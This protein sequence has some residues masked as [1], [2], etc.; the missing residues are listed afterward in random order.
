MFVSAVDSRSLVRDVLLRDGSTLRLEA[1]APEDFGDIKEFYEELSPE[2]R[3]LRFHGHGRVDMVARAEAEASGVD[4][5]ALIGRHDGRVIAVASYNG[6]REKC[7]A[8]VAFAVADDLQGRGIGTR[9][10][11]QLAEIAA[12]RGIHR[13]DADVMVADQRMLRVFEHAGFVVRRRGSLGEVTLS[14]DITP[15]D[16]VRERIGE[17]DHVGAVAALRPILAPRSI[18]VVGA[19][20]TPGNVGRAILANV[21]AGGFEGV[22]SPVNR[23]GGVVCSLNAAH[24]LRDLAVAPELVIIAPNG[25]DVPEFAAEAAETGAKALLVLPAGP[26]DDGGVSAAQELRLLEILRGA[27]LRMV[28]PGSL[29][30]LN[31]AP[32]V[33]LNATFRGVTVQPGGLAIGS[34]A[35]GLG[36][37]LLGHAAARGLGVS[38]FVSLGGR[39]DVSTS[40]LLEW[41]GDDERTT[42]VM[43]YVESFGD[44]QRFTRVAQRVAREKPV[45]VVKGGRALHPRLEARSNTAAALHGDAAFDALLHHAGVMR[46]HSGEDLFQTAE[47][48]ERQ[49]L[50]RGREVAIVSNSPS[51]ATF[52]ADA[53][54]TRGLKV[55]T[56]TEAANPN[57]LSLGAGPSEYAAA[58]RELLAD[59]GADSLLVGYVDHQDGDPEAILR[60]ITAAAAGASK[61]VVACVVRADGRLPTRTRTDVPNFL[62]PESCAAA[63]ART[64]QRQAW[65]SRP[66]GER[67]VYRDL[68][69]SAARAVIEHSLEARP[70]GGWLSLSE[71][72]AL[73]ATH[74]IAFA[75]SCR[76]RDVE[77]AVA[78][79]RQIGG[80]V[81]LKPDFIPSAGAGQI[82][83]PLLGLEGD[84][85]IRSGW[86]ELKRQVQAA[87]R[88]WTGAT[89][90]RLA[91]AGIDLLV[92]TIT[93]PELGPVIGVGFG[94]RQAAFDRSTAFRLPPSTDV[95][96]DELIDASEGV[97]AQLDSLQGSAALKREDLR[98]LI[99]RFALLLAEVPELVEADLNSVRCTT[100]GCVVL[101]MRMRIE[102][103]SPV[104]R[105]K[106]W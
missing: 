70:T 68:D 55:A 7:V 59:H 99:L 50:P 25:D 81:A 2:S 8:E 43:L 10:L 85:A 21:I 38:A 35:V 20:A 45:L 26:E 62:F 42:V 12:E 48:F 4:R 66:L 34:H 102:P 78:A 61:P 98:E 65:L 57:V 58:V 47:L 52:A 95:E 67:P 79:A 104:E 16:A 60:S 69:G 3:Y 5:L 40:D 28:G 91:A 17:R 87:G 49:P 77:Q 73:L 15:C 1:P 19:A 94:G 22:V 44:P 84:S 75:A 89:V 6:L 71:V 88:E 80:P 64:V 9:M 27:G 37:G 14:L 23:E 36:L 106:T 31:T 33:S 41:C 51:V 100:T 56:A 32:E 96:A 97:A 101:D 76:C 30:V 86:R 74:G 90:Q 29:G 24:S 72:Q 13:F 63:L 105:L 53:C 54:T 82:H 83:V 39:V 18:A 46:F 92:G 11:E 103:Q 93:D